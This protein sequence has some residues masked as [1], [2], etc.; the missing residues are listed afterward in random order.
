MLALSVKQWNVESAFVTST[1]D[2]APT[3]GDVPS[4]YAVAA[5]VPGV[6]DGPLPTEN[7]GSVVPNAG[8]PLELVIK[9][10][11]LAVASDPTVVDPV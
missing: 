4:E 11:L 3:L 10:E 8:T 1:P 6:N 5:P 2:A 9:M 7:G